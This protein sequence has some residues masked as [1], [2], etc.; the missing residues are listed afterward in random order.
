MEFS[1]ELNVYERIQGV[2]SELDF[3]KKGD[4]KVNGQYSFV[5]HDQVAGAVHPLLVKWGLVVIPTIVTRVQDGNRTELDISIDVV[6]VNKPDDRICGIKSTGYGIG[7]DDKGPGK[8]YSYAFKMLM[9]KLFVLESGEEDNEMSFEEYKPKTKKE[10]PT[11]ETT[12]ELGKGF[13]PKK[14]GGI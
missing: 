5:G 14:N 4:K 13:I 11:K 7:N 9:L 6:N 12:S 10:P 3:I 2:M 8:A 1:K